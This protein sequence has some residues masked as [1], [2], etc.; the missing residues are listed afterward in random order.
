M[1]I[2]S[3][4]IGLAGGINTY[5]Y[6][7]NNA[8]DRVDPRGLV[9]WHGTITGGGVATVVGA[10]FYRISVQSDCV[11][12]KQGNAEIVATGPTFG[13]EV[14]GVPPLT[15]AASEIDLNDGL[16]YVDPQVFNGWFVSYNIGI[17]LGVGYGCSLVHV[18]GNGM[19]LAPPSQ[20]G[21]I[22][23]GCGAEYGIDASLAS[24]GGSATVVKSSVVNC[25]CNKQ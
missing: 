12:G 1:Y 10:S 2:Q 20:A 24:T 3:D 15:L 18:G 25:P 6:V 17:S 5:T 8:I 4:P 21:A 22:S 7:G 14:K 11:N 23:V 13:A 9:A 19:T 16:S